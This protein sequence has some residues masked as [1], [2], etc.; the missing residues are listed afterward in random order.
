M[1]RDEEVSR[2]FQDKFNKS[3]MDVSREKRR[4]G[5]RSMMATA[6]MADRSALLPAKDK[7]AV[8]QLPPREADESS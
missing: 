1:L 7:S 6:Q 4:A 2:M 8:H 3:I 5:D